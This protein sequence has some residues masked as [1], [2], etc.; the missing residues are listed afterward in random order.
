MVR[1]EQISGV[2]SLKQT[3]ADKPRDGTSDINRRR[4]NIEPS[5]VLPNSSVV[6]AKA[7]S[8]KPCEP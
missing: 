5:V 3:R 8:P 6:A 4:H 1:C 2:R 7:D